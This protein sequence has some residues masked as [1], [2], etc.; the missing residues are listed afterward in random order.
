MEYKNWHQKHQETLSA[1]DRIADKVTAFAGNIRF[2]YIHFLWWAGWFLINS[3]LFH[4]TFDQYPYSLLTMILSLEAILLATL[5]MITQNRQA[6]RDKIQA[7]HQYET[8]EKEIQ[9]LIQI[10]K[11]QTTILEGQNVIL[12]KLVGKEVTK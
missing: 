10:N 7:E 8:Q 3:S 1:S 2:I 4:L 6:A 12:D 9:N 11:T 5:I